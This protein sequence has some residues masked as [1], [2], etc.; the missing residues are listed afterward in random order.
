MDDLDLSWIQEEQS[1]LEGVTSQ[2]TKTNMSKI[3]F[4][5]I[6]V[7]AN[8]HIIAHNRMVC[9]LEI[10]DTHSILSNARLLKYI[11]HFQ[12]LNGTRYTLGDMLLYHVN[13]D[14]E[15]IQAFAS[16]ETVA[17]FRPISMFE[18]VVIHPSLPIFHEINEIYMFYQEKS[19]ASIDLV[20]ILKTELTQK[21]IHTKKVRIAEL[22]KDTTSP[23][24]SRKKPKHTRKKG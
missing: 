22:S 15:H 20:S 4:R 18:D 23:S 21:S 10:C 12:H 13:I 14:F 8:Q 19:I 1:M 6:Y 3:G 16:C 17:S 24:V 9:S 5:C 7:G 11:K 2:S